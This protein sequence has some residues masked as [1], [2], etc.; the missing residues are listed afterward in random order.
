MFEFTHD[1]IIFL[2][3]KPLIKLRPQF[4]FLRVKILYRN[5]LKYLILPGLCKFLKL[6]GSF[7]AFIVQGALNIQPVV[8]ICGKPLTIQRP[9]H[10]EHGYPVLHGNIGIGGLIHRVPYKLNNGK[11][12]R[13]IRLPAVNDTGSLNVISRPGIIIHNRSDRTA[14]KQTRT[15]HNGDHGQN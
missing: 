3:G 9:V 1:L 4:P 14:R 2:R 6:S 10:I 7:I 15:G 5:T 13:R 8:E 12:C 11:H